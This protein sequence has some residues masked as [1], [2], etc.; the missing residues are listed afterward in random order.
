VTDWGLRGDRLGG[1]ALT[2]LVFCFSPENRSR[3]GFGRSDPNQG[4][5][6][7]RPIKNRKQ[8]LTPRSRLKPK[9]KLDAAKPPA[10]RPSTAGAGGHRRSGMKVRIIDRQALGSGGVVEGT[11]GGDERD[12]AGAAR[13]MAAVDFQR[14][15]ELHGVI[16]AERMRIAEPCGFVEQAGCHF[17]DDIPPGQVLT[18]A[19]E[20]RRR[21][22]SGEHPAL[23]AAGDGAGDFDGGDV[24]DVDDS[25]WILARKE[26]NP[27]GAG[28]DHVALNQ[29]T[30]IEEVRRSHR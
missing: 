6:A 17:D 14:H 11:V 13:L 30:G 19:A 16:G 5:A 8:S 18:E 26:A 23:P 10:G 21:L 20:E 3:L 1:F 27:A 24:G 12:R 7:I 29:G 15:G 2:D 28:F 9:T 25:R 4:L 22:G